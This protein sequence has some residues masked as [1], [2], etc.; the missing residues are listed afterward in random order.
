MNSPIDNVLRWLR[1]HKVVAHVPND[2]T[3]CDIGCGPHNAFL[4]S[5]SHKIKYGIGLDKCAIPIEEGNMEIRRVHFNKKLPIES[6]SVGVVSM[7]AVLEHVERD[8]AI[9]Q[10]CFRILKP[11]GILL[12]TVPTYANKPV[13]EFLA[14]RLKVIDAEQ[15]RDH[16]RYYNKRE[17]REDIERAGFVGLELTYWELGMNLFAKAWKP[18]L[19]MQSYA[20]RAR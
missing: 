19:P 10:G 17:I 4:N 8:H 7:L 2:S 20:D 11:G 9:L 5:V 1:L 3:I 15:Y 18:P 12:I 13:G 16:K 6:S 14:Y